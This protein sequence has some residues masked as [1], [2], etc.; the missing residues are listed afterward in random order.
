MSTV[1][2]LD[3]ALAI[4][5]HEQSSRLRK[6]AA[7]QTFFFEFI[8]RHGLLNQLSSCHCL[9]KSLQKQVATANGRQRP[10]FGRSLSWKMDQCNVGRMPVWPSTGRSSFC[11]RGGLVWRMSDN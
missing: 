1:D 6:E 9:R 2:A 7:V 4:I 3:R 11:S 10:S 5:G 8:I